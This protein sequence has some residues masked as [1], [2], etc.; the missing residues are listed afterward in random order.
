MG[1]SLALERLDQARCSVERNARL[2][3][4]RS[5]FE[6]YGTHG[7]QAPINEL[8]LLRTQSQEKTRQLAFHVA[9]QHRYAG[10]GQIGLLLQDE[11]IVWLCD[12]VKHL[13]DK[14]R[15]DVSTAEITDCVTVEQSVVM[16]CGNAE[17]LQQANVKGGWQVLIPRC[18]WLALKCQQSQA[19]SRCTGQGVAAFAWRAVALLVVI[20][21]A[22]VVLTWLSPD[23]A[24]YLLFGLAGNV[25]G[26]VGDLDTVAR[27]RHRPNTTLVAD[28]ETGYIAYEPML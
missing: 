18:R 17:P 12:A 5:P 26:A 21:A 9:P 15:G 10:S 2:A 4:A 23:A 3:R 13:I 24:A 8:V 25:S 16:N 19:V 20:S 6:Q 22:G 11:L 14:G 1:N 27:L 7:V 28:T